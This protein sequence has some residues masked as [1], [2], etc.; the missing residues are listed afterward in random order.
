[1]EKQ[2]IVVLVLA[3]VGVMGLIGL[4]PH[5]GK[6][7]STKLP[8]VASFYP[9]YFFA[10][11]IGGEKAD[12]S[13]IT[14]SGS[15]PHDYEVT[16]QDMARIEDSKLLVINGDGLEPWADNIT[17]MIDPARTRIV[18]ASKGIALS[19]IDEGGGQ[20][21]DP[22]VWLSP[23][24]AV[25][26]VDTVAEGFA[27]TD[28][29]NAA[30]Y[31]SNAAVLEVKLRALD[32]AYQT[33]L[34]HCADTNII[35]A[36]AAFGYLAQAYNLHQV[37]IAGL[38]PDAEPSPKALADIVLFARSHSVKYI[39]FESLVSPK[40][41]RTVASEVGAKV[42]VLNP[43]E[44]LTKEDIAAGK[45]YLTEMRANLAN[46]IIALQCTT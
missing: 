18:T 40:L 1:M 3:L 34:A 44:G 8:V 11:E 36:H 43:L 5:Q 45:D 17:K 2:T 10:H 4:A 12:V 28:P 37:A 9:L 29:A 31:Q 7:N 19:K 26:I 14:P 39:F 35:T 38:S 27:A 46:L 13:L 24:L 6:S 25:R 16:A 22:H 23:K 42:L 30:Y 41:A 20:V 32:E 33:G 15:E 21:L